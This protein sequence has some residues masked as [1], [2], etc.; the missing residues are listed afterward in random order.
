MLKHY[1]INSGLAVFLMLLLGW[2]NGYKVLWQIFGSSNQ[3]LAALTLVVV[4]CWL[5]A[6]GR[7]VWYTLLPAIFMLITS[8][9]MLIRLLVW[10]YIPNWSDPVSPK[11][12]LAITAI[13]VLIMTAGIVVLAIKKLLEPRIPAAVPAN[14]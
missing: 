8:V 3:L 11:A 12:P 14:P 5:V 4:T 9:W 1:W 7:P 6:K 2:G 13:I 10:T